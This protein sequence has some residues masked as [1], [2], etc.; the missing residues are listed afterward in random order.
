MK[1]AKKFENLGIDFDT[2]FESIW[3]IYPNKQG[4]IRSKEKYIEARATGTS[5]EEIK[6]GLERYLRY[7][8]R[9]KSWYRP[10]NGQTWFNGQCW[11]DELDEGEETILAKDKF[12]NVIL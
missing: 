9:E 11:L 1:K 10:K 8:E 5:Y 12:G 4:K 7:C 6:S 3:Q 2:E